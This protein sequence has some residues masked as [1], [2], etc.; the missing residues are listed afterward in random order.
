MLGHRGANAFEGASS[1]AAIGGQFGAFAGPKGAIVG[2][3]IGAVLG[4]LWGLLSSTEQQ[5]LADRYAKG[6]IE[7]EEVEAIR[8]ALKR[9]FGTMQQRFGTDM[10]R[11]GLT[12]STIAARM[13]SEL[14][15]EE[16]YALADALADTSFRNKRLGMDMQATQAAARQEAV[17]GAVSVLGN[18]YLTDQENKRAAASDKRWGDYMDRLHPKPGQTPATPTPLSETSAVPSKPAVPKNPGLAPIA[19]PGGGGGKTGMQKV[20]LKRVG[21]NHPLAGG[22]NLRN[23]PYGRTV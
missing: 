3:G 20:S 11:R 19:P 16:G 17:G 8:D 12:D 23:R 1:G 14:M 6:Y 7:P 18:L 15:A 13:Q 9:R 5:E 4:G 21:G 22:A 2:A 10:A